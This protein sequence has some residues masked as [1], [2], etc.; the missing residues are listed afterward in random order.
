MQWQNVGEIVIGG[1]LAIQSIWDLK[2]REIL[3]SV[4]IIGAAGGVFGVIYTDRN[5]IE[6]L[7]AFV[8]AGVCYMF[9][10]L[11]QGA[12]GLGDVIV[13]AVLA[14]YYSLEQVVSICMLACSIAA[15]VAIYLLVVAQKKGDYQIP[16]V[17]FLWLGWLVNVILV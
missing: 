13:L 10:K 9:S 11:S 15:V 7:V 12:L 8:P 6:L 4:S 5:F 2:Y 3:I 14:F 17:P 16:F 1:F